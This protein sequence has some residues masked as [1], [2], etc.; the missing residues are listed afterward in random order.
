VG[1]VPAFECFEACSRGWSFFVGESLR[2]LITTG[3][4]KPD[5]KEKATEGK[6]AARVA[7]RAV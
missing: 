7:G 3:K 2:Q 5:R 6:R 4:G 1:L